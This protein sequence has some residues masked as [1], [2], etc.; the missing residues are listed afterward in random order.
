M[1]AINA[2]V[3]GSR[4]ISESYALLMF[5]EYSFYKIVSFCTSLVSLRLSTLIIY[6]V[7]NIFFIY[8]LFHFQCKV[9]P[10]KLFEM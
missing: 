2:D 5:T 6:V 3:F 10:T 4:L 8:Y 7:D 9:T 1:S